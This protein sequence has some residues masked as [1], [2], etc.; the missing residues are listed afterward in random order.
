MAITTVAKAL[1]PAMISATIVPMSNSL[2]LNSPKKLLYEF[3]WVYTLLDVL[4]ITQQQIENLLS[5]SRF[6]DSCQVLE[7]YYS[8]SH[9]HDPGVDNCPHSL[10]RQAVKTPLCRKGA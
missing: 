8:V 10:L 3:A 5:G 2:L 1:I 9:P 7:G 6:G 4:H